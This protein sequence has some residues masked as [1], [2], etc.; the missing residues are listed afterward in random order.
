MSDANGDNVWDAT[1]QL[2]AGAYEFKFAYDNWTGQ[3]TLTEGSACTITTNGFTNRLLTLTSDTVLSKVCWESC[4]ACVY[5]F[6]GNFSFFAG[7]K[8]NFPWLVSG[9]VIDP[10]TGIGVADVIWSNGGTMDTIDF[11]TFDPLSG[12]ISPAYGNN[13]Y[14]TMVIADLNGNIQYSYTYPMELI[15]GVFYD[16]TFAGSPMSPFY[17]DCGA[18]EELQS[19]VN[20]FPNPSNGNIQITGAFTNPYTVS[21]IDVNGRIV[22]VEKFQSPNANLK[23][24]HLAD[25]VYQLRL[26]NDSDIKSSTIIIKK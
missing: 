5:P 3:E 18:V 16:I 20:I 24:G 12:F 1:T 17:F 13:Y 11:N 22:H 4:N 6:V 10:A 15:D 19:E 21:V 25:G 14:V 8:C 7:G 2:Q 23:L 9:V 26:S